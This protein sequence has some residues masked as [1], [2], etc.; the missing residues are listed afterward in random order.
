MDCLFCKIIDKAIPADVVYEDDTVLAFSDINPQA[1]QHKLF[2]PKKHIATL[3]DLD[4]ED[5]LLMGQVIQAAK[6]LAKQ[7]GLDK[8]GYR[9]VSNCGSQAHQT[10]FHIHFHLIGGRSMNWPPG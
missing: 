1:P 9:L 6:N 5:T 3:N 4:E 10:V 7:L 2:V 8:T